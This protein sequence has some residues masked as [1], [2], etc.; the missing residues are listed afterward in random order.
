MTTTRSASKGAIAIL[1]AALFGKPRY[2]VQVDVGRPATQIRTPLE[3]RGDHERL[4]TKWGHSHFLEVQS[5]VRSRPEVACDQEIDIPFIQFAMQRL[6]WSGKDLK[7]DAR[8]AGG[9]PI[10]YRKHEA[11]SQNGV[12]SYMAAS[13]GPRPDHFFNGRTDGAC[14]TARLELQRH[15]AAELRGEDPL[16]QA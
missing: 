11:R 3:S 6:R 15:H 1:A 2:F 7:H 16:Y 4:L 5:L 12:A 9:Y 8:K 14:E 10:D 13:G